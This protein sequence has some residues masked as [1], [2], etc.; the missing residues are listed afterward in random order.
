[1]YT[2]NKTLKY[3]SSKVS[4]V[5]TLILTLMCQ[6]CA[7]LDEDPTTSQLAPG[8]FT[9]LEDF[10]LGVTGVYGKLRTASQWTTFFVFGW[11]GD[12]ITTHRALNKAPFREYDQMNVS[13]DNPRSLSNW[14]DVYSMIRAV[15]TVIESA[16]GLSVPDQEGY[17]RLL[18]ESHFLRGTLFLHMTRI[19]GRIPLPLSS[20]PDFEI[21]LATQQEV[22]EQVERDLLLAESLLPD[23]Y[24]G[25]IA[26][27]P[28]P[29]KGSAQAILS[30]LYLN[31]AG[32]PLK[33]NTKYTEAADV[34]KKVIDN[35]PAHG[36]E[37]LSDL[38]DLWKVE[39][40]FN[41][42]SVWTIAY[43]NPSNLGNRK[44]GI[45][46][47]PSDVEGGWS[48]TFAEV[49]FFEDFPEGPR[50]E[51]TYRTDL[52]WKN[53]QDQVQPIFTKIAGPQG[54]LPSQWS[55]DR[56]DFYMR[57]AEVLLNYAE[58][59]GRSGSPTA[60]AW[61]ALNKIRRRAAGKP[62][63]TPD[64]SVDLTSGDLGELA[65]T[66]RKWEFAGEYL[67]YNDLVRMERVADALSD[68][69]RTPLDPN[70]SLSNPVVGSLSPDNYFAPIPQI[71]I[72]LNPNLDPDNN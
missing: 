29:N 12:D 7:D 43:S 58:A 69:A 5:V 14:N 38:N 3:L 26:G 6:N 21:G 2:K 41:S 46:G 17:D 51:A 55:T 65:F 16:Q 53:F 25:V 9:S 33:D 19:H 30:R 31:W 47:Y 60:E 68:Q 62:F 35:H 72:D 27:A 34:A 64:P 63:N 20:A 28:R 44:Y 22:Y 52:D 70:I 1:M 45:L 61:E 50:K 40:R 23:L 15:N 4:L 39:N 36:F 57:Y 13:S 11:A 37:L 67:R 56:N 8:Q 10:D 49:R 54:D 24:P 48:E 18:G 32:Y 42:E 59:S 66:E 71:E